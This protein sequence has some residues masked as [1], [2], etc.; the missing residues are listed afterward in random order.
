M[1]I[2]LLVEIERPSGNWASRER[3]LCHRAPYH[4]AR[5]RSTLRF[6]RGIMSRGWGNCVVCDDYKPLVSHGRCH[7]CNM[8]ADRARQKGD[9]PSF[10][11][12]PDRSQHK[13]SRELHL[14]GANF[15]R[16]L[17]MLAIPLSNLVVHDEEYELVTSTI[18]KW[19]LRLS[20]N[21][22]QPL[23]PEE[24]GQNLNND[25]QSSQFTTETEFTVN[26]ELSEQDDD[27]LGHIEDDS[28][29]E[30]EDEAAGA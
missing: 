1:P 4:R 10:L 26:S 11:S 13:A 12:A 24:T 23:E 8:H 5:L 15:Y 6:R 2:H 16:I 7:R 21:S 20:V 17:A 9:E 30:E 19:L 25:A 28:E 3:N 29:T 18:K 27:P 22:D 14:M